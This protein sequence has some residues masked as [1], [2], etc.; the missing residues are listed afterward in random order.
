MIRYHELE[1]LGLSVAAMSDRSDGDC[2]LPSQSNGFAGADARRAFLELLALDPTKLVCMRQVHGTKAIAVSKK[3]SGRGGFDAADAPADGDAI[4][5]SEPGL[6]IGICVADCVPLIM[7]D[8]VARAVAVV[9]AGRLSTMGNIVQRVVDAMNTCFDS[10]PDDIHA[11]IG[12][13][14]GP[15]RY[16]V[17]EA[18]ATEF[19]AL[20]LPRHGRLLDLWGANRLQCERA[21]I[22]AHQIHVQ[23]HC[24]L[25]DDRYFSHRRDGSG[26]RNL[27]V[28]AL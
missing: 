7:F 10:K 17:S 14:A 25:G 11:V 1:S 4:I 9:H 2:R 22:P 16:E 23:E 12:A 19:A 26:D 15:K 6:P 21:G 20:D 18:I 8:P 13:S 5:T 28:T 27:V 3:D 24:T